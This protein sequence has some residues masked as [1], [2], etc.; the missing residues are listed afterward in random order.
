MKPSR[1]HL[2][3]MSRSEFK[4]H[5]KRCGFNVPRNFFQTGCIATK[6]N[7]I[8]RFRWW[9]DCY[10]PDQEFYVDICHNKKEFDRWANSADDVVLFS[11]LVL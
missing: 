2:R 10:V 5:L 4:T 3:G 9:G 11:N 1:T 6:G 8:Y 7:S